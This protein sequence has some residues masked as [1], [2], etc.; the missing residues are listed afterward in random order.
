MTWYFKSVWSHQWDTQK[1]LSSRRDTSKVSTLRRHIWKVVFS[2]WPRLKTDLKTSDVRPKTFQKRFQDNKIILKKLEWD[3]IK[4]TKSVMLL[5]KSYPQGDHILTDD[6]KM[7]GVTCHNKVRHTEVRGGAKS[8]KLP[9]L[10]MIRRNRGDAHIK[11]YQQ[12]R[13]KKQYNTKN[14]A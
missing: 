6:P 14:D 2:A 11:R 7:K 1:V 13:E 4:V 9:K 12:T 8:A 10:A 3:I 5:E